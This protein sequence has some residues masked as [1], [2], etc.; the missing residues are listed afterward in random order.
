MSISNHYRQ[1]FRK[2]IHSAYSYLLKSV[3]YHPEFVTSPRGKL[4]REITDVS[5]RVDHPVSEPIITADLARN[6]VLADYFAKE[7][8]LYDSMTNDVNEFGKASKFWLSLANPDGTINS[9]YGHLIWQVPSLGNIGFEST[10]RTPWEW[11]IHSL[12][13]DINSRQAVVPFAMPHHYWDGNKDQVCTLHGVFHIRENRLNFSV[14][15]RSNDLVRGLAYDM[16]WFVH[17]MDRMVDELKPTYPS[18]TKGHYSHTTH[19]AHIYMDDHEKVLKMLGT[20]GSSE[21]EE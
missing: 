15:M 18:L 13:K 10:M 20:H 8:V 5:F 14:V 2:T 19:S 6:K 16:P 17:L 21:P 11:A 1:F 4:V 7:K 12:K 9:A 3:L